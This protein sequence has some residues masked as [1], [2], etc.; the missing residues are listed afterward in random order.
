MA[1]LSSKEVSYVENNLNEEL[2][3]HFKNGRLST[4]PSFLKNTNIYY[5]LSNKLENTELSESIKKV[6]EAS[7]EFYEG[8]SG[9][10]EEFQDLSDNFNDLKEHVNQSSN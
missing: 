2:P 3:G 10:S 8:L 9:L 6:N 1:K 5:P 4:F 7:K